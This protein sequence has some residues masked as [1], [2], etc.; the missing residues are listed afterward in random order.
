MRLATLWVN[1]SALGALIALAVLWPGR[2]SAQQPP[3]LRIGAS[4]SLALN[5]GTKD[6]AAAMDT[7]KSFIKS[8][9]GFDNEILRQKNWKDVVDQMARGQLDLGV[10]QGYEFAWAKEKHPELNPIAIAVNGYPNRY[11]YVVA[12]RDGPVSDFASLQGKVLAI[13]DLGGGLAALYVGHLA[14]QSGKSIDAFFSRRTTPQN[15]EDALDD[16]VDGVVQAAAVDRTG[17]EAYKRR[18]PGRF[19]K[20]KDVAHSGAFPSP[21]V[22]S[23]DSKLDS[24]SVQKIEDGL[25]NAHRSDRGQ[26]LLNLFMLTQF[27]KAPPD[28]AQVLEATRKNYPELEKDDSAHAP[29]PAGRR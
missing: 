13:P 15:V 3:K 12:R 18:K 10:F 24:Q 5:T 26:R 2:S 8:E 19:A 1:Y 6:D 9:T 22:A 20:L 21:V 25:L 28:F 23:Y 11:V 7:L 17:L 16:V 14:K 4:G 27:Q 29:A